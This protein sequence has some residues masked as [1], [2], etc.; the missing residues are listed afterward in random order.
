MA[1]AVGFHH[2]EHPDAGPVTQHRDVVGDRG[3]VDDRLDGGHGQYWMG[4][5]SGEGSSINAQNRSRIFTVSGPG[6]PLPTGSPSRVLI[7]VTPPAVVTAITS[8]ASYSS[9]LVTSRRVASMPIWSASSNTVL[10]VMP[11]KAF[12]DGEASLPSLTTQTLKPGPSATQ[13]SESSR[14]AV[15]A[16]RSLASK[17]AAVRS[18][19]W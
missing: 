9:R 1:V 8:S 14:I 11:G 16:P 18:P 4:S 10:R 2:G 12:R 13:L 7:G 3:Q 5:I 6:S 19:H 15:R 17:L